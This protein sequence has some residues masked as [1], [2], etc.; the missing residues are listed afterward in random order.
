TACFYP[1]I[2]TI[3]A[4]KGKEIERK[5][6]SDCSQRV[7]PRGATFKGTP[8]KGYEQVALLSRTFSAKGMNNWR[9]FQRHFLQ[10][11]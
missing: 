10:R 9:N 5:K 1:A 7:Q 4:R 11:A 2:C 3:L 8:C 6:H